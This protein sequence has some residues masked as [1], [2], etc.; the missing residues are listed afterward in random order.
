M[1]KKVTKQKPLLFEA[2]SRWANLGRELKIQ[3]ALDIE[4]GGSEEEG[5]MKTPSCWASYRV[6]VRLGHLN[7]DLTV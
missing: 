4:R 7:R 6:P 5:G 1:Q 3:T 2:T